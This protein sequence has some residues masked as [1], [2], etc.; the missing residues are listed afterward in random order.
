MTQ[1]QISNELGIYRT[2][3]SRMLKKAKKEGIVE[4][5]IHTDFENVYEL[6]KKMEKQF[7]IKESI[8]VPSF[9]ETEEVNKANVGRAA[10]EYLKRI[11]KNSH[12]MGFAWGT[13][14]AQIS[15]YLI[16]CENRDI[17]IMCTS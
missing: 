12:T 2:T 3:I 4:I 1:S 8:I 15:N 17:D 16:G 10:A 7:H 11:T 9:G 5:K 13:T 14:M 6:E